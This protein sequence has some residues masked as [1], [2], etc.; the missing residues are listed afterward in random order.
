MACSAG[1]HMATPARHLGGGTQILDATIGA[2]A[3]EDNWT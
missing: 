2:A 1:C 3:N